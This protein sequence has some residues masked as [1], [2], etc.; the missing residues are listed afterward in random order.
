MQQNIM[1][2]NDKLFQLDLDF[3]QVHQS[4]IGEDEE[5]DW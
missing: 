1:Q 4:I 3:E 5:Y 2:V